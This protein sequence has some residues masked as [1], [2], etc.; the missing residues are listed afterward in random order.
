[1]FC[2]V[3]MTLLTA[4]GMN[5][6]ETINYKLDEISTYDIIPEKGLKDDIEQLRQEQLEIKYKESLRVTERKRE[7]QKEQEEKEKKFKIE[8]EAARKKEE[9]RIAKIKEAE[10]IISRSGIRSSK[11]LD[12]KV[13]AYDLSYNSCNKALDHPSYG[14][15][16]SGFSLKGL[17]RQ[18]AMAVAA[19]P[20]IL[21]LGTKLKIEFPAGYEHFNGVYTVRD[22]GSAV[23][24]HKIDLFMG[25]FGTYETDQSVW[26]FGVRHAKVEILN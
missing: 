20:H 24:G 23:K 22:T 11:V 5:N 18:K 1:M 10:K 6:V 7:L 2:L 12:F 25:D 19:D 3:A 16:A 4:F 14:V 8:Q 15:T 26:D 21:P 17:S 9:E 13:T